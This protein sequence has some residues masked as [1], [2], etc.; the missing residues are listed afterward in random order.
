MVLIPSG[1][2]VRVGGRVAQG[3]LSEYESPSRIGVILVQ[4]CVEKKQRAN[5]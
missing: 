2:M 4:R 3:G 5:G 1:A